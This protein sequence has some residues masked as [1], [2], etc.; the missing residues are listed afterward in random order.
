[1]LSKFVN[2]DEVELVIRHELAFPFGTGLDLYEFAGSILE[3][4]TGSFG[5]LAGHSAKEGEGEKKGKRRKE[6]KE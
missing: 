5:R 6:M 1:M 3:D 2:V 4:S